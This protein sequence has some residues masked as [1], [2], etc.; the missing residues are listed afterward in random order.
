MGLVA[1]VR[2]GLP[3]LSFRKATSELNMSLRD[4][5][6]V[7]GL[8]ARSI[9]RRRAG[10][11]TPLES[12]RILRLIRVAAR[13]ESVLGDAPA[14]LDWLA[15]PNRALDGEPPMNLLDTDLGA[16]QVFDVLGR[17]EHGVYG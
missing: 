7:L 9:Q 17:I 5:E 10:R 3:F 16:K 8:S 13:A 1:L 6:R 15:S 11:L 14:A 12:E 2:K 4:V